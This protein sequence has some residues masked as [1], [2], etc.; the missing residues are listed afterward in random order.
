MPETRHRRLEAFFNLF[1]AGGGDGR[2]RPAMEGIDGGDDFKTALVVAE[3]AGELEQ[4]LVGLDA[5]VGKETFAGADEVDERLRESPLRSVI[6][7]I[8]NMD[9]LARLLDQGL[10]DGRGRMAERAD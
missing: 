10:G 6:I 4:A 5:A 2:K 9:E 3:F 7:K 8:G 1:L